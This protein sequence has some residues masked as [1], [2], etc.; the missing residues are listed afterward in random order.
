MRLHGL[1]G[2]TQFL[3]SFGHIRRH[4]VNSAVLKV[5]PIL[6]HHVAF[7]VE[8]YQW[9]LFNDVIYHVIGAATRM[10]DLSTMSTYL[11]RFQVHFAY[12]CV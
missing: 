2:L 1:Q 11:V 9:G 3:Q 7:S 5:E 8:L 10:Y 4:V 12:L 6:Y